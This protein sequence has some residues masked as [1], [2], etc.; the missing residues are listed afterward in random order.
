MQSGLVSFLKPTSREDRPDPTWRD[1]VEAET[2]KRTQA[3]GF[4]SVVSHQSICSPQTLVALENLNLRFPCSGTVWNSTK[5]DAFRQEPGIGQGYSGT[6]AELI[7]SLFSRTGPPQ[8]VQLQTFPIQSLFILA[9]ALLHRV[10]LLSQM[11]TSV[12]SD[13][14]IIV[15]YRRLV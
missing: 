5:P 8:D 7:D 15:E 1:W 11:P 6:V 14:L 13:D 12:L 9:T 3:F 4:L 2:S 10:T